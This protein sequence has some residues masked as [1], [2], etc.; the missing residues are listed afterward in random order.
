[1]EDL[2]NKLSDAQKYSSLQQDKPQ[3]H[4]EEKIID[5]NTERIIVSVVSAAIAAV[6]LIA[7]ASK[8]LPET[9]IY[10]IYKYIPF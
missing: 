2:E 3:Y 1:M 6:P 9:P 4:A 10:Q 8:L 7:L 5:E